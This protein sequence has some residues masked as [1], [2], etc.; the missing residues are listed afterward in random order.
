VLRY[1]GTTGAFLGTF[2][3]PDSG[4]L[5]FPTFMTFTETDPSTLN[6]V[7]TNPAHDAGTTITAST[8]PTAETRIV[9]SPVPEGQEVRPDQGSPVIQARPGLAAQKFRPG[10]L[11]PVG[12]VSHPSV[13]QAD[14]TGVSGRNRVIDITRTD[15]GAS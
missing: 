11:T 2:V 13:R 9:I 10:L 4:G 7:T 1:D 3:A 15:L 6:Y 5:R 12:R 8:A 14:T